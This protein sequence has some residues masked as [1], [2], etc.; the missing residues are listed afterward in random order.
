M[1]GPAPSYQFP[2]LRV[3]NAPEGCKWPPVMT[4]DSPRPAGQHHSKRKPSRAGREPADDQT[5][6]ER[7]CTHPHSY[8]THSSTHARTRARTHSST[9]ARTHARAHACA[10]M[11]THTHT[12][13]SAHAHTA[14]AHTRA[15]A[16]Y[17][18]ARALAPTTSQ[19]DD[20]LARYRAAQP[21]FGAAAGSGISPPAPN[22]GERPPSA[23]SATR[24]R[25]SPPPSPLL[26]SPP[27]PSPLYSADVRYGQAH[28]LR[29]AVMR[30]C[31]AVACTQSAPAR[32]CPEAVAVR[33]VCE[34]MLH[35]F[36]RARQAQRAPHARGKG[37]AVRRAPFLASLLKMASWVPS[38]SHVSSVIRYLRGGRVCVPSITN[39]LRRA[40]CDV[41]RAAGV[42]RCAPSTARCMLCVLRRVAFRAA[43]CACTL[44]RAAGYAVWRTAHVAGRRARTS[45]RS[46][47]GNGTAASP[48]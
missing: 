14:S 1:P 24:A 47:R 15:R 33:R 30:G 35:A 20:Q 22:S 37:G 36:N 16:A 43:R 44:A 39:R 45:S 10:R 48:P 46:R 31:A 18:R 11:R 32:V 19:V 41:E 2:H 13:H 9:R 17:T 29:A 8:H 3:D 5:D 34:L 6:S 38:E 7:A 27:T 12:A 4:F 25:P 23:R 26:S 28:Q 21:T 40:T 42:S